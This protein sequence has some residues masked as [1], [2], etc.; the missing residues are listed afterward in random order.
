MSASPGLRLIVIRRAFDGT[1]TVDASAS[2]EECH[3][4]CQC[5]LAARGEF[6]KAELNSGDVEFPLEDIYGLI[7]YS[8]KHRI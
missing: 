4:V 3:R 2:Y 8:P 6:D 5:P 1:P 7:S